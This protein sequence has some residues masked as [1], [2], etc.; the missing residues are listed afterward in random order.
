VSRV[1]VAHAGGEMVSVG[2]SRYSTL[3]NPL[4]VYFVNAATPAE[5]QSASSVSLVF[6][7]LCGPIGLTVLGRFFG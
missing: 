3:Y 5:H 1:G 4:S 7:F 2:Q 6:A